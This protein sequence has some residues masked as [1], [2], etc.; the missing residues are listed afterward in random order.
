MNVINTSPTKEC[1]TFFCYRRTPFSKFPIKTFSFKTCRIAESMA[2]CD[3]LHFVQKL[4]IACWK[5][6]KSVA[7][8]KKNAYTQRSLFCSGWQ[9]EKCF[10]MLAKMFRSLL[11]MVTQTLIMAWVQKCRIK[12]KRWYD[13]IVHIG[14]ERP[15]PKLNFREYHNR[16]VWYE[17]IVWNRRDVL[18]G[19]ISRISLELSYVSK[20]VIVVI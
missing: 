13:N 12:S 7:L 9:N 3:A 5:T 11:A 10:L 1:E 6:L 19:K 20:H 8:T 16:N 17:C 18:R 14:R 15:G 4:N 2:N